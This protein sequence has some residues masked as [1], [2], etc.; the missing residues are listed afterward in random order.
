MSEGDVSSH[1]TER[2]VFYSSDQSS[3]ALLTNVLL[4]PTNEQVDAATKSI[5]SYVDWTDDELIADIEIKKRTL[6]FSIDS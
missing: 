2:N 6:R 3:E 1:N 5:R 4:L